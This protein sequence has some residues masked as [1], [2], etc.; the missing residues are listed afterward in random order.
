MV[1]PILC[2]GAQVWGYQYN[3]KV[4]SVHVSFCKRYCLIP[5][6]TTSVFVYGECGRLPLCT[7]YLTQ[8]FKYWI[9]V[10]RMDTHR[11]P[12]HCYKM[13]KQ[14]DDTGRK[15][16]ASN[17]KQL[18][19]S[20]GFGF[21]WLAQDVGDSA[22]FI[23]IFKQRVTDIYTQK[24]NEALHETSKADSSPEKISFYRPTFCI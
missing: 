18:L 21:V 19:F 9:K 20:F 24:W 13:L 4:E 8:S 16:W 6:Q 7:Y 14:L 11:Y 5:K 12:F 22:Q 17:I 2:Y 1:R 10:L 3:E 23:T 15:P